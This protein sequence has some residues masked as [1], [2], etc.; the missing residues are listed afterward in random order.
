MAI[1]F[2][3]MS[4]SG[5]DFVI[6]DNRIPVID[7]MKKAD[8]VK[9]VCDRKMSVGADGVIFVENSDKADI[10]WDFYNE[11]GS[12]A[13]MCGNG[14]RCVARYAAEMG[15]TSHELTLETVA[16]IIGAKV[17]GVNVRVKLTSPENLRQD[18]VA[19]LNGLQYK[20]DSLNTGVPHAVIYTDDVANVNVKEV[21]NGI[22]FH[23]VFAPSGTNV[24]F[25]E[26]VGEHDLKI[27]TYE[28]GVEDETLACGTGTVAS[29][30]VSSYKNLVKPPVKV[31]T[32]GGE[33]LKVDFD[34]S[35]ESDVFL[36]GLTR[37]AFEGI[38]K[39]Y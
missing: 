1:K 24:N 34:P 17:N 22:R 25:V 39:E 3:K 18:L 33:I 4:G 15:I 32:R 14:G 20:I 19:E 16:G 23:E 28:R 2:T 10:K 27:R 21:G 37:I 9:R 6:I 29:A 30:L 35:N 11:D 8:F 38:L 5:N 31:E 13:E 12:S 7:D 26:K 36:E